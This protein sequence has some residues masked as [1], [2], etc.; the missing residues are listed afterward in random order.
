[1]KN[2]FRV[3]SLL[4]L[5]FAL[6]CSTDSPSATA[7][8]SADQSS[9][10]NTNSSAPAATD[11]GPAFSQA[12]PV[13]RVEFADTGEEAIATYLVNGKNLTEEMVEPNGL[14][15]LEAHLA[16]MFAIG[17]AKCAQGHEKV[18]FVLVNNENKLQ[19]R[20]DMPCPYIR[21][22]YRTIGQGTAKEYTTIKGANTEIIGT[23]QLHI[24][25]KTLGFFQNIV[26]GLEPTA[27]N[28]IEIGQTL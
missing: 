6:S 18:S 26:R 25:E 9:A 24:S 22:V 7:D 5:T 10:A 12:A 17:S 1:M 3:L 13:V 27:H 2:L 19:G 28:G 11:L 8:Q 14:N 20:Y 15:S 21:K 4:L 16:N 23:N